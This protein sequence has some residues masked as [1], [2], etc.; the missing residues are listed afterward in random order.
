MMD[1]CSHVWIEVVGLDMGGGEI[2]VMVYLS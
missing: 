2:V 1:D